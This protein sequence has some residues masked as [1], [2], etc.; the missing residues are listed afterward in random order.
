MLHLVETQHQD[1]LREKSRSTSKQKRKAPCCMKGHR[2][3]ICQS[4][5]A[6]Q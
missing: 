1:Q 4:N 2:K 5:T 6:G 3:S